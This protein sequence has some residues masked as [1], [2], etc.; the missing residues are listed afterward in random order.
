MIQTKDKF[1]FWS[2]VLLGINGI[3]GT[4]IFLLPN[5][6]Y[7]M[8]GT[9][10]LGVLFFDAILAVFI[11]LCF[12][13]AASFFK[14]NGG[15]YLY[16]K[17]ALGDFAGYEVGV[18][19][20]IVTLI[21]WATMAVGLATVI[22]SAI[23]AL[24]GDFY[25]NVLATFIVAILTGVNL[26]GVSVSKVL[27]N[28]MTVAK[29]VPL[30]LFIAIGAFFINGSNFTLVLSTESVETGSIA[31]AALLLFFA[32]TGFEALAVAAEDMENPKKNLPKAIV[33]TMILVTFIYMA[34]LAVCIGV[35]GPDLASSKT[36]IQDAFQEILGPVGMYIVFAGTFLSMLG[37]NMAEAFYAPRISTALAQDGMVPAFFDKRNKHDVP[38][39]A[40][41][42]TCVLTILLTWTGSF[43]QLAAIS[44]ISR[45]TQMVPTILAVIIF[46]KRWPHKERSYKIPFGITIPVIA[47]LI[48]LWMISNATMT[49]IIWGLGGIVVI[50][51]FYYFYWDKKRKGLIQ[52]TDDLD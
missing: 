40:A 1:G 10:S 21:A 15:P 42:I 52:E 5:K 31:S 19:K 11:A 33:V 49:Q 44:A 7:A 36:P 51:P 6:A 16:A 12:A 13:E 32:Y 45:F 29:L 35:M 2:I 50:A 22:Q 27:S 47:I 37:I 23:P 24:A 48:T 28:V 9:A 20:W 26:M 46:R 8:V 14:R 3:V 30:I 17:H 25:K 38:Y 4:G 43:T 34:I 18:L 39:I 41:I